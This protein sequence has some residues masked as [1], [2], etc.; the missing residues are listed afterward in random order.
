MNVSV[1]AMEVVNK[2]CTVRY[3]FHISVDLLS[4]VAKISKIAFKVVI[5]SL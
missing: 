4:L 3:C 1:Q 2:L 5:P